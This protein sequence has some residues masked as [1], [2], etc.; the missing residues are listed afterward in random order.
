MRRVGSEHTP[1]GLSGEKSVYTL[2]RMTTVI[3][4]TAYK[5]C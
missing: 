1:Q 4:T 3:S 2:D 5:V